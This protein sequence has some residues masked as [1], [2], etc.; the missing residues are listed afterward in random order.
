MTKL[1]ARAIT[2]EHQSK[3]DAGLAP[4]DRPRSIGLKEFLRRDREAVFVDRK[5]RTIKEMERAASHA[6]AALGPDQDV[7]RIEHSHVGRLK[8]YL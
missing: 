3:I 7:Q 8:R 4:V 1:D 2:R 5:R 6:V